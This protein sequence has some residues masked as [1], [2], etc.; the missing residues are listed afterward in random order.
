MSEQP[1]I[2]TGSVATDCLMTFPGSFT[3]QL[4]ADQLAHVS[5]SF[6]VDTLDIRQGGVGANIAYGLAL[7]GLRPALVSAVGA[8]FQPYA[9]RL[10][11]LGVDLAS[12]RTSRTRHTARFLCTTDRDGNQLASFY[13]GAM[14]EAVEIDLADTV[15]RLGGTGIVHIGADQPTAMLRHTDTARA[16]GV[17]FAA[18]PAQQLARLDGS[19][20]RRLVGGARFLF[21]NAY[22]HALLLDRTGWTEAE[23]LAE[24]DTWITTYGA[25]GCRVDRAGMPPV[26]IAAVPARSATDPTGVGDAFRAGFL[27]ATVRGL[28]TVRAAQAGSALATCALESVGPQMY[29][30]AVDRETLESALTA[31]Y[32]P[33]AASVA[34]TLTEA[35]G[36]GSD[37]P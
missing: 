18:D 11:A 21:T 10:G 36:R 1:V 24:T 5:L 7:L 29:G 30:D 28:D 4:L 26:E 16:L 13:P 8:D 27:A 2:V 3:E 9:A 31:A 17:P 33:Q 32:G 35:R 15:R 22:E 14:D 19:A 12:V 25:K 20:V 23:V 34:R 6:L 37:A